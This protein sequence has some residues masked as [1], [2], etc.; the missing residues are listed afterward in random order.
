MYNTLKKLIAVPSVSGN[1]RDMA[2][3]IAQMIAPY[4]DESYVDA[5]GN[6]IALRR[7]VGGGNAKK[8]LLCAH[9]DEIG[10]MVTHIEK[11]GYL[12]VAPIGGI[13]WHAAAYSHVIT[14]G[15][16][17]G[18]LVPEEGVKPENYKGD[19]FYIDIGAT[20]H[21]EAQKKVS[22][23]EHVAV[24]PTMTRLMGRRIAGRPLDDKLGCAI[25]LDI[26]KN[27]TAVRGDVYFVFSV[28]EEVG[29]RGAGP[30]AF[31]I[32]PDYALV[33][34]VTLT[35]DVPGASPM[36][37]KLG[38]GAAIKIK[39]RSVICHSEVVETL[40]A[41][42]K[43]RKIAHQFEILTAGGTDTSSIQVSRGGARAGALSVPTRYVH[44]GME[45][46]DL[47]DA[48]ACRDL[49]LAFAETL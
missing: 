27:L 8:L 17:H 32:E 25:L 16:V 18:V 5:M 7:G 35:G 26:A 46:A 36:A 24:A 48:E 43:E 33:F 45:T 31:G 21:K 2:E 37:V 42:A 29:C 6:L 23:G 4:V 34:D 49:A 19:K 14:R 11:E 38:D 1:E 44:T 41:L 30:A 12:R 13:D 9:M 22:V 3:T 39:D 40:S 47:R 20:S 15:G 10:F 28:Q